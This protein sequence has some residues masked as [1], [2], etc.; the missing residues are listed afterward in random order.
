ME[1]YSATKKIEIFSFS[2][3]CMELENTI[4]RE[5]RLRRPKSTCSP[6]FVNFR[7]TTNAAVLWDRGHTKGR[8]LMGGIGQEG[9]QK[10]E[11]G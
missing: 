4:L 6:S 9:M 7:P 5:V 11:C 10:L 2:N 3:K 8:M 1:F